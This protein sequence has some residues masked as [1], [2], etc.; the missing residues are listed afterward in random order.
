[1]KYYINTIA[2]FLLVSV[3]L[4]GCKNQPESTPSDIATPVSVLELKKGSISK[5][6]N[7]TGTALATY[8]VDLNS[9]MSGLYKLQINPRTGKPFKLGDL[10]SKGQIIIQLED[11]E[12][13]NGIAIKSF[14]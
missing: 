1:M 14:V 8:S 2:S 4:T 5:L 11:K 10:V 13:E 7:T 9:E 3:M 12:Y 6:V